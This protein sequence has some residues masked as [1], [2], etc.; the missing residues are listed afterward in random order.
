MKTGLFFG[1]FNPVHLGHTI[2]ASFVA[3]FTDLVEV[4]LVV[5]S[6]NP[7][8]T[9]AGLLPGFHR[10]EMAKLAIENS[11]RLKICE[12]EF[13]LPKPSYTVDT[14]KFLKEEYPGKQFAIIIGADN[15]KTFHQWKNYKELQ[16]NEEFYLYPRLN[17]NIEAL[18]EFK[19][20]HIVDAPL[21][22]ISSTFIRTSMKN[23]KNVNFLLCN[24]VYNYLI[25]HNLISTIFKTC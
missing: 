10:I 24:S 20:Y 14:L 2:I 9:S 8:K 18:N 4:W 22:E 1:S 21:I 16:E 19:N 11:T 25:K 13:S 23:G 17:T 5:S 7:L 15:V 12:A 3:E 6:Q